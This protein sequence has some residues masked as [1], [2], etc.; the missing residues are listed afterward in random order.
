MSDFLT[1]LT[2]EAEGQAMDNSIVGKGIIRGI[3][4]NKAIIEIAYGNKD[5]PTHYSPGEIIKD[6][7]IHNEDG[8]VDVDFKI[9]DSVLLGYLDRDQ[10]S[11]VII[12]GSKIGTK[13][14]S[15]STN[16]SNEQ[17]GNVGSF[18][19]G[20]AIPSD[21]SIEQFQDGILK[22]P[23]GNNKGNKGYISA[24]Y[25]LYPSGS[26]HDGIDIAS[27]VGTPILSACNGKVIT[28]KDLKN[29]NREY[30]S[31]GRYVVIE[32]LVD[33]KTIQVYY[34]H[35]SERLV[36]V[37]AIVKTGDQIGKMGSTGNSSGSHLH[38]E[39]R[40]NGTAVNPLPYLMSTAF[41][42][43][44]V[45]NPKG[46]KIFIDAGHNPT[47]YADTGAV[48]NGLHEQDI[49]YAVASLLSNKLNS[50]GFNVQ[51]SRP[52]SSSYLG[53]NVDSSLKARIEKANDFIS[54][55]TDGIFISIHCNASENTSASG[56]ETYYYN[57]S[58]SSDLLAKKVQLALVTAIKTKDKGIKIGNFYVIRKPTYP[59]ILI[60]I[61]FISNS[62][63]ASILKNKQ[64]EIVTGIAQGIIK[65]YTP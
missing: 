36:E 2:K 30:V 60:E 48:G 23:V 18:D 50:N 52:Q 28:S 41:I 16:Y 5:V 56:T 53:T 63:D 49:N 3:N 10:H 42:A 24:S 59:A 6:V 27:I 29:A 65:Y 44:P 7:I 17:V 32:A 58:N 26:K 12:T 38:F 40:E 11:I 46:K 64:N 57:T 34:C 31:Y 15:S 9:G 4:G 21:L 14:T 19:S 25:P 33:N 45:N 54:N 55:Q 13:S 1:K 47:G 43:A 20:I 62:A 37:G 61:A 35:M 39:I 51:L 22:W 8:V